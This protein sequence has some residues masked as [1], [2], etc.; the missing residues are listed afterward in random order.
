MRPPIDGVDE[1]EAQ[2]RETTVIPRGALKVS[3]PVWL[4]N[5]R[6]ARLLATFHER[7]PDVR[8]DFDFE[9]RMAHLI[10]E[11]YDLAP[12]GARALEE[13]V[14]ARKLA[15]VPFYLVASPALLERLGRPKRVEDLD[16][17]PL[18]AYAPI[19]ADGRLRVGAGASA[20]EIR[21]NTVLKSGNESKLLLAARAGM[22]FAFM[23]NPMIED[24]V[25]DGRLER[26]LEAQLPLTGPLYAVYPDRSFLPAKVRLL[27][28]FLVVND[29]LG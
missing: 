11:G 8:L 10:E 7:Y 12:R 26:V 3:L 25:R 16:G 28:D 5:P 20:H 1:T 15:D 19:I 18:L 24:S 2:L 4:V 13:G 6:F 27:L 21:F 22:G 17:L 23:P 29:L 9:G 14:I